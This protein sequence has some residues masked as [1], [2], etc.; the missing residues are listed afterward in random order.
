MIVNKV[1]MVAKL[2]FLLAWILVMTGCRRS[3]PVKEKEEDQKVETPSDIDP[4]FKINTNPAWKTGNP[5]FLSGGAG[6]LD[7]TAVKDPSIV[8]A[9][10]KYHL[11]Y[12]GMDKGVGGQ[13][14][15][16]YVSASSIEG[17]KT[18]TPRTLMTSLDG[19]GYFCAPQ[20]FYYTPERKWYLIYQSGRGATFSTTTN[21]SDPNSWTAGQSM[22]FGDGID[23]WLVSDGKDSMFCFY[24][25]QD[26]SRTIKRRGTSAKTF[27]YF[28]SGFSVVA[29]NTFEAVHVYKNKPDGKYY[30]IV[31]D[32]ARHFELWVADTPGGN[33][34]KLQ[35]N[36]AA[37][38]NLTETAGHWTDQVSHGEIIRSGFDE[39]MK[40]DN[41]NKCDI[42]IQGVVNSN[43]GDYANIPYRLG[44]IK[45]Y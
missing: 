20:V 42:L 38:T 33:W 34:T 24:S 27:P 10:G 41:I 36:W 18:A 12:T 3:D 1:M 17:L 28:W 6:A 21:I 30:M 29:D 7:A 23:F 9:D 40:I 43:Y 26:G 5:V 2:M 15:T 22:G 16:G 11:F 31:E 44:V 19:G 39:N 4:G 37:K 13:W 32:I 35:E 14:K 8:F 25:A 45:N